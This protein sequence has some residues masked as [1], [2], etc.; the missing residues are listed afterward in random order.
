MDRT[1]KA[2]QSYRSGAG[3]YFI[4]ALGWSAAWWLGAGAMNEGGSPLLLAGGAGPALAALVLTHGRETKAVQRDY[5]IR[6]FDVRR[7]KGVWWAVALFL[8]PALL[9]MAYGVEFLLFGE[10]P[11][12]DRDMP[13]I[14][15]LPGLFL[16]TLWFGPL[17]EEI[18]W[19]G[20]ALDRLQ[21]RH[22]AL[23]ASLILGGVWALWHLPLFLVP[24][25]YQHAIGMGSL[26]A[27]LYFAALPPLSVLMT[28]I[29]NSTDRSTLSAVLVHFTGNLN[30]AFVDRTERVVV[31]EVVMLMV[32]AAL[33]TW[34]FGAGRLARR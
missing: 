20:Y 22:T 9:A 32:A 1:D 21:V 10:T 12:F 15:A 17:P 24:G 25:T 28:W 31:L 3:V 33:V 29:Y 34:R 5:W 8:H 11:H 2:S 7:L 19:R 26:R 4:F 16:V 30:G 6:I 14:S 18:G 13:G 23:G 27:W